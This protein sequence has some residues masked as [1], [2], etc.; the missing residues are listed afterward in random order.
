MSR[1]QSK[2]RAS[3]PDRTGFPGECQCDDQ[4]TGTGFG[5]SEPELG[6]LESMGAPTAFS[7]SLRFTRDR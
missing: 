5:S 4:P 2:Q 6:E 3:E 7:P 1:R